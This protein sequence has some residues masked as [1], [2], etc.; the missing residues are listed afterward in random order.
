MPVTIATLWQL[1]GMDWIGPF[2][3]TDRGST[4][5]LPLI[6]YFSRMPFT[7]ASV[8]DGSVDTIHGLTK[9]WEHFPRMAAIY[10]DPGKHYVSK[11]AERTWEVLQALRSPPR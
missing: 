10:C 8:E 1:F 3:P 6:D 2:P 11:T 5:V 7:I 9:S 4:R